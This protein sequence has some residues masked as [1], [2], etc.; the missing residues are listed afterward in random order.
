MG[1]H[2]R[3]ISFLCVVVALGGCSLIADQGGDTREEQTYEIRRGDTLHEIGEQYG[4]SA[5]DLQRYNDIDDPRTL[6]VGQ[7][8]RIPGVG[9]LDR[10]ALRPSS[11][12]AQGPRQSEGTVRMVSITPVK[13][14]VGNLGVPVKSGKH[15]SPFGWR[16]SRFHEGTDL[17]ARKGTPV[18][19]AHDGTVVLV[20]DS[21]GRYGKVVVL[22]GEGLLTVYSHNS[23]NHVDLGDVVA[24]GDHIADVGA[25]GDATGPHLH[26]ETRIRDE[27]GH[28]AAVDP[29]I[30][31][32]AN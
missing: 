16:W 19:A 17:A 15:S 4:V 8:I 1:L 30:F 26:F 24:K 2:S 6:Q 10:A 25:S 20:T 5:V 13:G 21:W 11:L 31:Y 28:F 12:I 32:P 22:Q 3:M 7:L 14:Y 23:R 27:N 29:H 9:P 18:L